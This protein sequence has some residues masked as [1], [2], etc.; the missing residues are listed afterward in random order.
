MADYPSVPE[1]PLP[2]P[3]PARLG[4]PPTVVR[5]INALRKVYGNDPAIRPEEINMMPIDHPYAF[6]TV[7]GATAPDN[8]IVINPL[9]A[10]LGDQQMVDSTVAH[11]VQHVRQNPNKDLHTY[12]KDLKLPYE[13][14]PSEIDARDAASDFLNQDPNPPS[15]LDYG[16][17]TKFLR[18]VVK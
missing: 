14:R 7:N 1:R 15:T 2:Q 9:V 5:A 13:Q 3:E 16:L 10:A 8:Q 17:A 12:L 4:I 18:G 11:E 6:S